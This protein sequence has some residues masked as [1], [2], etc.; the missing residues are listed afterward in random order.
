MLFTCQRNWIFVLWNFQCSG[1]GRSVSRW[2]D[3]VYS[4]VFDSYLG[5]SP[6]TWVF[7]GLPHQE[8][9]VFWC[10]QWPQRGDIVS[11][12]TGHYGDCRLSVLVNCSLVMVSGTCYHCSSLASQFSISKKSAK[13][14]FES[15]SCLCFSPS[16]TFALGSHHSLMILAS[17]NWYRTG[18][19]VLILWS[20]PP[21]KI[22]WLAA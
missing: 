21:L 10:W 22:Y 17:I 2:W 1:F 12:D 11:H 14:Y 16:K 13:R 7:L 8:T 4:F 9:L 20:S 19:Q 6:F 5:E 15:I 3:L 18:Y